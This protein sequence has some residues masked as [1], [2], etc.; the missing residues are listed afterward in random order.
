MIQRDI[1]SIFLLA[2]PFPTGLS[3]LVSRWLPNL[4]PKAATVI[5]QQG[6]DSLNERWTLFKESFSLGWLHGHETCAV[7]GPCAQKGLVLGLMLKTL[8]VLKFLVTLSLNLHFVSE[9]W[10]RQ[11]AHMWAEELCVLP[12]FAAVL[13]LQVAQNVQELSKTQSLYNVSLLWKLLQWS[14]R[15]M[16][17]K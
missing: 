17:V 8:T 6:K 1:L 14:V 16:K 15:R 10:M 13:C 3:S 5:F 12:S 4:P 2:S 9:V 7:T 11:W